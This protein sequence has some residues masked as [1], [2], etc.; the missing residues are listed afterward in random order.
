MRVLFILFLLIPLLADADVERILNDPCFMMEQSKGPC[1]YTAG[2]RV[3]L[4]HTNGWIE[5]K[6]GDEGKLFTVNL[7]KHFEIEAIK[8]AEINEDVIF[9]FSITDFDSGSTIIARLSPI[10]NNFSWQTILHAF[11]SSPLLVEGNYVYVGGIGVVSKI[12]AS[13]GKV[14][15]IHS[16]LYENDTQAYNSFIKPFK[17]GEVVRFVEKKVSSAKYLGV[18]KVIV[19][20]V[21][22]ELLSK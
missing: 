1:T 3:Y 16:G 10:N 15:W 13:N 4:I 19:N 8:H 6:A 7:P 5:F 22:G 17:D 21:T 11:N 14:L 18:R 20:D 9:N 12:D 2:E